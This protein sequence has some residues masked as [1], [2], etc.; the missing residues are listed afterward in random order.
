MLLS[1][2]ARRDTESEADPLLLMQHYIQTDNPAYLARL[3]HCYGDDLYHFLLKQ[4]DPALAADLCQQSW[5]KVMEQ[6]QQFAGHSSVKTWLFAI[7]RHLLLD[8]FRKQKKWLYEVNEDWV[9][10]Q[11]SPELQLEQQQDALKLQHLLQLLP[12]LQREALLLQLEGF[13]LQQI[14]QITS[15]EIETVKSR[16]RYARQTLSKQPGEDDE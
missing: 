14:A 4:S 3:I 10:E 1:W 13:S 5:L 11:S 12:L 15:T 9:A 7:G 6:K 8:E 2:L 16:L